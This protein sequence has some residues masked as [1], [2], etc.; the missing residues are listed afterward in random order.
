MF[1]IGITGATGAGKTSALKALKHLDAHI[2][3]CDEVY[4]SLLAEDNKLKSELE[5]EFS[6]VLKDGII[7]R[8]R[9][10]EIVFSDPKALENLNAITHKYIDAEISRQI[11]NWEKKGG[12]LAA[13]DA[14]ALIESGLNNRCNIT[15]AI[16]APRE[17]RISRIM[18]RDNITRK[19]AEMRIDAQKS[20][21]FYI[22]HSDC[23]LENEYSTSEEF[24][25][26]CKSFFKQIL[27]S[28]ST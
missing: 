3:D 19:K 5:A 24:E 4:H 22:E 10:G 14:I 25:E 15:T 11:S 18:A 12:T 17:I 1:I 2:I 13:I 23:L 27:L 21:N 6:A 20:D 16:S 26:V 28:H 7:D 9:L 8:K